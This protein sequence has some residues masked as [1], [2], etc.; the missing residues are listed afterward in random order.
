MA[1][2]FERRFFMAK[3]DFDSSG[4]N[5]LISELEH[6]AFDVE[7]PECNHSFAISV[8]DIG[9]SVICPH[10]GTSVSIESETS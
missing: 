8:D 2:Y 6:F 10:C 3:L 1:E 9:K 4:F 5:E 7:C